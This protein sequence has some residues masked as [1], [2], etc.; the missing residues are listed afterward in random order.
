MLELPVNNTA[1]SSIKKCYFIKF[2]G[3]KKFHFLKY[4]KKFLGLIFIIFSSFVSKISPGSCI[5]YYW[6]SYQHYCHKSVWQKFSTLKFFV[7]HISR[8]LG[9][10]FYKLPK[11]V[12]PACCASFASKFLKVRN[13]HIISESF[14]LRDWF[15]IEGTLVDLYHSHA[16]FNFYVKGICQ[17]EC[18]AVLKIF[19][20]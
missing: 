8:I 13:A 5:Y 7:S 19:E 20:K 11:T 6:I 12:L 15:K 4:K 1:C 2:F 14:R 3:A 18:M 10:P 16:I 9:F 17:N